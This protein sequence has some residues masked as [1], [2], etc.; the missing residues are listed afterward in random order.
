M[1]FLAPVAIASSAKNFYKYKLIINWITYCPNQTYE[2]KIK[3]VTQI[4]LTVLKP[5]NAKLEVF[6]IDEEVNPTKNVIINSLKE[7]SEYKKYLAK[8][9][10]TVLI[11]PMNP[12]SNL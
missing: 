2:F 5:V 4:G 7:F 8:I 3:L 9:L 10:H 1:K 12:K 6:D 11:K